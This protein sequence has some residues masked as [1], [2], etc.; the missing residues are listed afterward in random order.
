MDPVTAVAV[1]ASIPM[2]TAVFNKLDRA[3]ASEFPGAAV[4]RHSDLPSSSEANRELARSLALA[5]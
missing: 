4:P 5:A 3:L 1:A 2:V